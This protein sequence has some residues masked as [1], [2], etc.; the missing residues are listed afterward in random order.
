MRRTI[1]F[2]A[3]L[4]IIVLGL[5]GTAVIYL[6]EE[7]LKRVVADRIAAQTGRR[8]EILGALTFDLFPR[9][10]LAAEGVRI[11]SP[12]DL[13][14]PSLLRADRLAMSVEV[15]PLLRGELQAS[16]VRMSGATINVHSDARG[17]S[18]IDGLGALA[19]RTPL[20]S[21][22][23]L[24]LEDV[25]LLV[26][27]MATERVD[28]VRVD[29]IE[30]DRF[31]LDRTV[32]F[33]FRGNLGDPPLFHSMSVDGQLEVPSDPKAPVRLAD[34][35]LDGRMATTDQP[36]SI[37]GDLTVSRTQPMA[38][39]LERGRLRIGRQAFDIALAYRGGAQPHAALQ[40]DASRLDTAE[41]AAALLSEDAR[42]LPWLAA[43]ARGTALDASFRTRQVRLGELRLADARIDLRSQ[44][45]A[46]VVNLA[47]AFP[48]G[49]IEGG[50][51]LG[52]DDRPTSLPID[53]VVADVAQM[54]EAL[55]QPQWLTGSGEA[56]LALGIEVG[57][58][59]ATVSLSGEFELWDGSWRVAAEQEDAVLRPFDRMSGR[60]RLHPDHIELPRLRI[61]GGPSALSGWAGIDLGTGAVAG[62][63]IDAEGRSLDL[64]GTLGQ[65]RLSAEGDAPAAGA[66]EE[67]ASED[68]G[69]P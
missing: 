43:L 44:S 57:S 53:V 62:R 14:G 58:E 56:S 35:R 1:I 47:A 23:E 11:A 37:E 3:A 27:D 60:M 64:S 52:R 33:R 18:S 36:M 12:P 66:G 21:G 28:T 13:D 39:A 69:R 65:A 50:G 26:S 49:L 38:L 6:D 2:S 30:L 5:W 34:M 55:G 8:V 51:Q 24:V 40:A 9:P 45:S 59:S 20:L 32:A 61:V 68:A 15:L 7:R 19:S 22:R 63:L 16:D 31:S 29:I 4:A 46:W 67:P 41:L 54:L 17:R 42:F 10:R 25:T 48:G